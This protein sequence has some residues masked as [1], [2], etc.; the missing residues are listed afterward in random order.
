[1]TDTKHFLLLNAVSP[2]DKAY[3]AKTRMLN[4]EMIYLTYTDFCIFR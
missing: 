2:T 1:M 3:F 4:A